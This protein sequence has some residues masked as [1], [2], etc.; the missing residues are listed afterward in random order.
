MSIHASDPAQMG[1]YKTL[2]ERSNIVGPD[3]LNGVQRLIGLRANQIMTGGFLNQQR[4]TP[5]S[6]QPGGQRYSSLCLPGVYATS[7]CI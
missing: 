1:E 5:R 2:P 6:M 7:A 3:G 4:R